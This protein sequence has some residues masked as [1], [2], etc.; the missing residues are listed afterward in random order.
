MR[1]LLVSL[2]LIIPLIGYLLYP[3]QSDDF[4]IVE[5]A[6]LLEAKSA[7][8][9]ESVVDD[10][11]QRLNV[12]WI[13]ADDLGYFDTDLYSQEGYVNTPNLGRI[14]Q[15]GLRFSN[16]YVTSPLCSPSRASVLTGRYNQR[17]GFEHQ[18]HDRYLRNR[19]EY[20]GFRYV[21]D[22]DPW[23]PQYK[24]EVPSAEFMT[25]MSLPRSEITIAEILKKYNYRTGLI[26]KWHLSKSQKNSPNDFGFEEFYGFYSSHSLYS[27][28]GHRR[29]DRCS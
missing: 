27:P 13:M 24:E 1:I 21:I 3:L 7:Y 19:L 20:Y 2:I 16:A 25:D 17:F 6:K 9:R 29:S 23:V 8:L 26:G 4:K 22:S 5:N 15:R 10:T 14:A 12:V 11:A 18:L 28:G